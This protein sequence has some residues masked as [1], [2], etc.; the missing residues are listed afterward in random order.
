[1]KFKEISSIDIG[2][3]VVCDICNGDFTHSDRTGGFLLGSYAYCPDCAIKAL[4]DLEKS[5]EDKYIISFCLPS[6]S[7]KDFVLRARDG[8]NKISF[9]SWD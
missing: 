3:T 6:I 8:N 7:F 5:G 9:G 2:D 1:M 4:P